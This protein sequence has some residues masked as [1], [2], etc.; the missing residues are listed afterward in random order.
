MMAPISKSYMYIERNRQVQ[1]LGLPIFENAQNNG[2][3][4]LPDGV[5]KYCPFIIVPQDSIKNLYAPIRMDVLAYFERYNIAWWNQQQDRYFP[6][7]HLLSSQIHCLNH[8]F[9]I[10]KDDVAVLSII[11][12][13]AP[14]YQFVKV[15]PSPIDNLEDK[16]DSNYISFEFTNSNN[17]L[18]KERACTRGANCTSID[19]FVYAKTID[20]R[21]V[22]IAIEWK[23]TESYDMKNPVPKWKIVKRYSPLI[24][25]RSNIP[26]WIPLYNYDP[27]YE[28]ARQELLMEQIINTPDALDFPMQMD[29]YIHLI[30]CPISHAQL[31]NGIDEYRSSLRYPDKLVCVDPSELLD[32]I[33][34][35]Y[36][37][38][39]DYLNIRY[40]T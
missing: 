23:Y 40:W 8:L 2:Y 9:A 12:A 11:S 15:L 25:D 27:Y 39:Y 3:A 1:K 26:S 4:I 38:L 28:F 10:R 37:D 24:N 21:I 32:S 29:D 34:G 16:G 17:R 22:G 35:R 31:R 19:A 7:G 14:A 33:T 5:I 36:P 20:G 6:T 18:L 30:V 13:I